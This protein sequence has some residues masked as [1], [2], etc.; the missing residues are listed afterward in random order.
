VHAVAAQRILPSREV[1]AVFMDGRDNGAGL[2]Y[3][4]GLLALEVAELGFGA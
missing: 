2:G 1:A 4:Q 3:G